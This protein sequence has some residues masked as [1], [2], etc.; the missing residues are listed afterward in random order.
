MLVD[1]KLGNAL[2]T[3][4]TRHKCSPAAG[5]PNCKN[6]TLPTPGTPIAPTGC[7]GVRGTAGI[8]AVTPL[9]GGGETREEP[10]HRID[11]S[12]VDRGLVV[13]AALAGCESKAAPRETVGRTSA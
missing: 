13:A 12:D 10:F 11:L 3:R 8:A 2:N 9:F 7:M 6:L 4:I 5:W 1:Q